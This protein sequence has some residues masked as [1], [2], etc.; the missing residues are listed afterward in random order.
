M[1]HGRR[2]EKN[3]GS[4]GGSLTNWPQIVAQQ[5]RREHIGLWMEN[6]TYRDVGSAVEL[7][8]L[9]TTCTWGGVY[10]GCNINNGHWVYLNTLYSV[11]TAD[12]AL[13]VM[14]DKLLP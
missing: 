9:R 3:G 12:P 14:I 8:V 4:D 7:L 11:L 13:H 5:H 2:E 1:I 10:G 6:P